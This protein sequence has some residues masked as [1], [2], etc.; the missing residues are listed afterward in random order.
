MKPP[1]MPILT[2]LPPELL[3][4]I[5]SYLDSRVQV[6]A[7]RET[8]SLLASIGLDHFNDEVSLVY[9]RDRFRAVTEI[10]A[11]PKLS[12]HMRS[13]FYMADRN[14]LVDFEKRDMERPYP[15]PSDEELRREDFLEAIGSRELLTHAKEDPPESDH[16]ESYE[17][18]KALCRDQTNIERQGYDQDFLRKLFEG[19]PKL[20]EVTVASQRSCMRQLDAN[21]VFASAMTEPMG[22]RYWWD[23]IVHQVL[24]VAM[25]AERSGL[26]LDSLTLLSLS[27]AI[28]GKGVNTKADQWRALKTLVRP[29]RRLRLY[30]QADA[31]GEDEEE[32]DEFE[33]DYEQVFHQFNE[34]LNFHA[35]E[36]LSAASKLRSLKLQLPNWRYHD[37]IEDTYGQLEPV[38][39]DVTYPNLYELSLSQ[40]EV[41]ADYLIDL[42]MR[43][44]ATLRRLYLKNIMLLDDHS[45][46]R[47][48]FTRLSGQLPQLRQ[49][50]LRGTFHGDLTPTG[51]LRFQSTGRQI[52]IDPFRDALENFIVKG[53]EYPVDD[54][55]HD[56]LGSSSP[57]LRYEFPGEG[58]VQSGLPDDDKE[59]D[60]PALDYRTDELD[61][62][63]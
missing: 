43:H 5:F 15:E 3:H 16:Q 45:S 12:K 61:H 10:A 34:N 18:F 37:H 57:V 38:L 40:C 44:K 36:I 6:V 53:G 19:C 1:P 11:H 46:F 13:L 54:R 63:L 39:R 58:W 24:S 59:P 52:T 21:R 47:E 7:M 22:D 62:H 48:V 41:H 55:D 20:R 51:E 28:F 42:C 14:K 33:P 60:D 25:A 49:V 9:H 50:H 35:H 17:V 8:C 26:K 4:K 56:R 2:T 30:L 27:P 23:E 32:P 31:P 29:L